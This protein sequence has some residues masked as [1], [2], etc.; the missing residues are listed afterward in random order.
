MGV[1][2]ADF[3]AMSVE[4]QLLLLLDA[5]WNPEG[6]RVIGAKK[7]RSG[8]EQTD[9]KTARIRGGSRRQGKEG[10]RWDPSELDW[11]E[12]AAR[13]ILGSSKNDGTGLVEGWMHDLERGSLEPPQIRLGEDYY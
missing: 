7:E 9:A 12:E 8:C 3:A 10:R 13:I 2:T 11:W 5:R 1:E 6:N 4:P